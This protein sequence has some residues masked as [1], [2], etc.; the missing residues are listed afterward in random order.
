MNNR[1]MTDTDE[2]TIERADV[3]E[4]RNHLDFTRD[5]LVSMMATLAPH[6]H[7]LPPTTLGRL[8][9]VS[10][11]LKRL[12]DDIECLYSFEGNAPAS[13]ARA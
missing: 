8:C 6:A 1:I 9:E 5:R 7:A 13:E 11:G 2:I 3:L 10:D 12:G 4:L